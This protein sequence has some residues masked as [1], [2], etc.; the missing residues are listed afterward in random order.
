MGWMESKQTSQT[1]RRE[2][3]IRGSPQMRQSA[4]NSVAK[5]LSARTAV[6][7]MIAVPTVP[8]CVARVRSQLLLKT[9]SHH[10][11]DTHSPELILSSIAVP[12]ALRQSAAARPAG[13][14]FPFWF[15]YTRLAWR[16]LAF[17][18]H[19]TA[20]HPVATSKALSPDAMTAGSN[21]RTAPDVMKIS[22]K[23]GFPRNYG[24][25][26]YILQ[27]SRSGGIGT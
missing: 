22:P 6:R 11:K 9:S 17:L 10:S 2:I 16:S 4:G 18:E 13:H 20:N 15:P 1:G 26:M 12:S 19:R 25:A 27:N 5:R 24:A 7:A 14:A 8:V 23:Y 21:P 3:R